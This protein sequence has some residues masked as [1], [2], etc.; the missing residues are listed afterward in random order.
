ML[1]IYI[2]L[3]DMGNCLVLLPSR[4]NVAGHKDTGSMDQIPFSLLNGLA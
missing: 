4:C 3:P 1:Y 2:G